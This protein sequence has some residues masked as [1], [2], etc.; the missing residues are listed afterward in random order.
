MNSLKELESK[1][2]NISSTALPN[3]E[4]NSITLD[5]IISEP[6]SNAPSTAP[7][8]ISLGTASSRTSKISSSFPTTLFRTLTLTKVNSSSPTATSR[9][10]PSTGSSKALLPML[11]EPPQPLACGQTESSAARSLA[12]PRKCCKPSIAS[13]SRWRTSPALSAAAAARLRRLALS[14]GSGRQR[15]RRLSASAPS[16]ASAASRS[17]HSIDAAKPR[18]RGNR[19]EPENLVIVST[20][21]VASCALAAL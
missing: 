20:G 7:T 10:P 3:S 1:S 12:P 11:L 4:A 17:K 8:V 9:R 15:R 19:D 18:C 14:V 6:I 16:S 2:S 13:R 21:C 5:K